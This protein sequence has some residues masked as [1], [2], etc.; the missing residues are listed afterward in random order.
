[1]SRAAAAF[2]VFAPEALARSGEQT[3]WQPGDDPLP[4]G[5][6]PA[7]PARQIGLLEVAIGLQPRVSQR[8]ESMQG[9][10]DQ[11]CDR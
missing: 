3:V 4:L 7:R 11:R 10:T 2:D 9:H 1:M 5:D 8:V 6:E